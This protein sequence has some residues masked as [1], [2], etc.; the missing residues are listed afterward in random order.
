MHILAPELSKHVR[1]TRFSEVWVISSG[2]LSMRSCT[3]GSIVTQT[4]GEAVVDLR[5]FVGLILNLFIVADGFYFFSRA[6]KGSG[7]KTTVF[8][9]R[10]AGG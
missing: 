1:R 4:G 5:L 9:R 3:H 10:V 6:A 7:E 8:L 2:V